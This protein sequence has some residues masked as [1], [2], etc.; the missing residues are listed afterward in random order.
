[1]EEL[2][3]G[4]GSNIG[5][6]PATLARARQL[7]FERVGPALAQSSVITTPAWG[8][9]QQADFTNQIVVLSLSKVMALHPA[10]APRDILHAVLD[11]T[12]AVEGQLGRERK[13]HWGPRTCDIDLIFA[14]R[15]RLETSRLSLPHPWWRRR[16][17][18]AGLLQRELPGYLFF[19][20]P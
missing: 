13:D 18:V 4:L 14:G 1:M 15:T 6:G 17:F 12:Q 10:A 8:V 20:A 11:H 19:G 5:D 7:L 2:V 9:T 16:D 3:V